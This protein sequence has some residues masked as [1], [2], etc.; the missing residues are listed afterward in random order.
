MIF[1][2][3]FMLFWAREL[4]QPIGNEY[5]EYT[6]QTGDMFYDSGGKDGNYLNCTSLNDRC[7][8]TAHICGQGAVGMVFK[9]LSIFPSVD[10]DNLIVYS[11]TEQLYNNLKSASPVGKLLSSK[12]SDG[13]LTITFMATSFNSSYG[14]EASFVVTTPTIIQTEPCRYTCIANAEVTLPISYKDL[15]MNP[16][17]GCNYD[18]TFIDSNGNMVDKNSLKAGQSFTYKAGDVNVNYCWGT[19]KIKT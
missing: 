16:S 18:L 3:L 17:E 2:I 5:V 12:S 10:G 7:T 14:W 6:V 1:I 11:G 4:T 8:S 19:V 13:C 15:V 9:K